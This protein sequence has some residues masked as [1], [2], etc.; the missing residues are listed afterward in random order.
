MLEKLA[1]TVQG[2]K[3]RLGRGH[4]SGKGKTSGRG[5]KGQKA[6]GRIRP[7]FEGGQRPLIKRLPIR[8]GKGNWR[9]RKRLSIPLSRLSSLSAPTVIDYDYM[10]K[11]KLVKDKK[12]AVKIVG[13]AKKLAPL[14][15]RFPVTAGAEKIIVK[16]KGK[17]LAKN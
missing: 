14:D 10:L 16:F 15:V 7:G 1:A 17:V 12:V 13:D 8:R 6:R 4:S 9:T 2:N 11:N 5:T 3:K